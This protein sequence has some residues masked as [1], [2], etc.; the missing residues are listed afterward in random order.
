MEWPDLGIRR[1]SRSPN[2][3]RELNSRNFISQK[4]VPHSGQKA[5]LLNNEFGESSE[6]KF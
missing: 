2:D 4:T 3:L 5:I 6:K 1:G